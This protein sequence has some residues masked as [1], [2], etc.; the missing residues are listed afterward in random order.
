MLG[1]PV[2]LV[3][4]ITKDGIFMQYMKENVAVVREMAEKEAMGVGNCDGSPA[5]NDGGS[6]GSDWVRHC[7]NTSRLDC[8]HS[9]DRDR[10]YQINFKVDN[11]AVGSLRV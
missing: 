2:E 7:L 10:I 1:S 5:A 6:P 9:C 4:G 8:P 11:W 3:L